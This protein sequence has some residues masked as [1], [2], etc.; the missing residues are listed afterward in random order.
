MPSLALG[1]MRTASKNLKLFARQLKGHLSLVAVL[2]S[3]AWWLYN[4]S[5]TGPMAMQVFLTDDTLM[6]YL[7]LENSV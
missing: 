7:Q 5:H 3:T 4:A 2:C 1:Q 6:L